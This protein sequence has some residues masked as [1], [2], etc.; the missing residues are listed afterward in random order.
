M[1]EYQTECTMQIFYAID[2]IF[3][4][5]FQYICC[6]LFNRV[7]SFFRFIFFFFFSFTLH[8]S[9]LLS[10]HSHIPAM[11]FLDLCVDASCIVH[12]N[13]HTINYLYELEIIF[14][15]IQATICDITQSREH[16]NSLRCHAVS[17][18]ECLIHNVI[19]T[20]E[21][22]NDQTTVAT[23]VPQQY[24]RIRMRIRRTSRC[25]QYERFIRCCIVERKLEKYT[26]SRM[27][28][29]NVIQF[30]V[31]SNS[32]VACLFRLMFEMVLLLLLLPLLRPLLV[33]SVG[34]IGLRNGAFKK[35]SQFHHS[36]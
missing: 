9:I 13:I 21:E 36:I 33:F 1:S 28:S 15:T 3:H 10:R 6:R 22:K 35:R 23:T 18:C 4:S 25:E 11:A 19:C 7:F 24:K 16:W 31:R 32:D 5:I 8:R 26:D 12:S 14:C 34:P 27:S 29:K 2:L 30:D 17:L 20:I